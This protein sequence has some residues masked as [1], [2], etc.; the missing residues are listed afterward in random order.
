VAG[1]YEAGLPWTNMEWKLTPV[2][3]TAEALQ[4][5]DKIT[6]WAEKVLGR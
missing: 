1:I 3:E 6:A 4:V 5:Q 2:V